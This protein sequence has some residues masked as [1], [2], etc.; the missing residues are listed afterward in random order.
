[1]AL[2]ISELRVTIPAPIMVTFPEYVTYMSPFSLS[3]EEDND[4]YNCY[5]DLLDDNEFYEY[6]LAHDVTV[7]YAPMTE[8][9]EKRPLLDKF[10]IKHLFQQMNQGY[11]MNAFVK[12][13]NEKGFVVLVDECMNYVKYSG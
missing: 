10:Q 1:M 13:F 4:L 3:A 11:A 9:S 7:N 5:L 6:A 2:M 12:Q 8:P